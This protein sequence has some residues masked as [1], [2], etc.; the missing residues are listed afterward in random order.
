MLQKMTNLSY[1]VIKSG[2]GIFKAN[3]E[4]PPMLVSLSP[5]L[6]SENALSEFIWVT[7]RKGFRP[8]L[9][10]LK[11]YR[12]NKVDNLTSDCGWGCTI[13]STQ[14]LLVNS[15]KKLYYQ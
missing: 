14:M 10:E 7:Y 8:L 1:K 15:L 4:C 6:E 12:G 9:V 5:S 13:R 3:P 11:E 2:D